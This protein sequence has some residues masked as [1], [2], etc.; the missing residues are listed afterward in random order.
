MDRTIRPDIRWI[1][2]TRKTVFLGSGQMFARTAKAYELWQVDGLP[3]RLKRWDEKVIHHEGRYDVEDLLGQ[4]ITGERMSYVGFDKD[5]R[6]RAWTARWRLALAWMGW[7]EM[8]TYKNSPKDMSTTHIRDGWSISIYEQ[9]CDRGWHVSIC[10]YGSDRL[11]LSLPVEYDFV[12]IEAAARR[13]DF[14]GAEDVDVQRVAFAERSCASCYP[15]AKA[16]R[17]YPGWCA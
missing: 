15:A 16:K 10:G 1:A 9:P 13:C 7:Q 8:K 6:V 3:R 4:S 11:G 2:L 5:G 12:E 14:C 17:E